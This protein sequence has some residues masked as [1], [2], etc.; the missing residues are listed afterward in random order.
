[1]F[2]VIILLLFFLFVYLCRYDYLFLSTY[3]LSISIYLLTC[4]SIIYLYLSSLFNPINIVMLM[5][6]EGGACKDGHG[7][8]VLKHQWIAIVLYTF[9]SGVR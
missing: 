5:W 7:T 2:I 6:M 9:F 1:M 4:L 3:H 8:C